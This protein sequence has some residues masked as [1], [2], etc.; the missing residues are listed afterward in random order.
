M[1]DG[2]V[3]SGDLDGDAWAVRHFVSQRIPLLV[4]QSYAKNAGL[5][6]ERIGCLNVVGKDEE[7]TKKILSQLSVLQRSEIS[8][9]PTFG[10]RIV[11]FPRCYWLRSTRLTDWQVSML[12]NDEKMFQEWV[13]DVKEMSGRIIEMRKVLYDQLTNKLQTPGDWKHITNQIGMFSFTGLNG[14]SRH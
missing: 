7:E 3:Q 11:S 4:C 6:G 5:Y 12:L 10:A 1:M 14:G 8:N 13:R 2:T 9:P